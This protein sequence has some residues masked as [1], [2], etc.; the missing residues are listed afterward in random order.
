M[1]IWESKGSGDK[2][3]LFRNHNDSRGAEHGQ[4]TL[5]Q[6][7][8]ANSNMKK[9]SQNCPKESA[10]FSLKTNTD[11]RTRHIITRASYDCLPSPKLKSSLQG[12]HFQSTEDIQK[13]TAVT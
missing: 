12:T 8:T 2:R 3:W 11:A 4:E 13:K 1:K 6:S 9:V 7:L 5:G 10:V